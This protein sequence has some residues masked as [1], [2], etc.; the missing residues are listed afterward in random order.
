MPM[1]I[2][3]SSGVEQSGA[4][5]LRRPAPSRLRNRNPD[6]GFAL[7]AVADTL[8]YLTDGLNPNEDEVRSI[9]CTPSQAAQF[10]G[11]LVL[12]LLFTGLSEPVL[13]QGDDGVIRPIGLLENAPCSADLSLREQGSF[14]EGRS[15]IVSDSL[16]F[17]HCRHRANRLTSG[18]VAH[19]RGP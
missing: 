12:S 5:W 7:E 15:L 16:G 4:G 3:R 13:R 19:W 1:L 14:R 11:F 18:L 10:F 17:V 9:F 2:A 6:R 8:P